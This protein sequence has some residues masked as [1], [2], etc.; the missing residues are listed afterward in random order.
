MASKSIK[1]DSLSHFNMKQN[2]ALK[3]IKKVGLISNDLAIEQ[4]KN[5]I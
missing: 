5:E 4:L 2:F 3:A 1:N